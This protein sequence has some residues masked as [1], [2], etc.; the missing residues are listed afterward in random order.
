MSTVNE[1]ATILFALISLLSILLIVKLPVD[2]ILLE[3]EI[4]PSTVS[5]PDISSFSVFI[6]PTVFKTPVLLINVVSKESEV[7]L[8]TTFIESQSILDIDFNGLFNSTSPFKVDLFS[9][10]K[11]L[12]LK[13]SKDNET[14][15]K[16][17]P[18]CTFKFFTSIESLVNL[19]LIVKLE[20][21]SNFNILL[22]SVSLT[23]IS[24]Y[25]F[26]SNKL[27][28]FELSVPLPIIKAPFVTCLL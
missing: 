25:L 15:V 21:L 13:S 14:P 10:V 16:S 1:F 11:F 22:L 26:N 17:I 5:F 6:I 23:I 20:F 24:P 28:L 7:I 8:A 19:L 27:V 9:T 2:F 18:F 3:F 4:S 12:I